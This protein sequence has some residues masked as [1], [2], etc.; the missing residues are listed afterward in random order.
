MTFVPDASFFYKNKQI[1]NFDA[2]NA[3]SK[4]VCDLSNIAVHMFPLCF[5]SSNYSKGLIIQKE[6]P[7][8]IETNSLR[9]VRIPFKSM[10]VILIPR[11]NDLMLIRAEKF[12]PMCGFAELVLRAARRQ[13]WAAEFYEVKHFW[14][15]P[16]RG[17]RHISSVTVTNEMD[18]NATSGERRA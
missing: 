7:A 1:S 14:G 13:M 2:F 9:R 6:F 17:S 16:V 5:T 3:R 4:R 18:A 12:S 15:R 8:E 10:Q 11:A